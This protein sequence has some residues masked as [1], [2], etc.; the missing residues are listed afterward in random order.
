MGV[1]GRGSTV[2]TGWNDGGGAASGERRGAEVAEEE[3]NGNARFEPHFL[4]QANGRL[5]FEDRDGIG[6]IQDFYCEGI[7]TASAPALT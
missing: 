1:C 4:L 3:R 6:T 2:G 5:F 7:D